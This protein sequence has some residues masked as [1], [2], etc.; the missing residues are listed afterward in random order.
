MVKKVWKNMK[1][2]VMVCPPPPKSKRGG[3][4]FGILAISTTPIFEDFGGHFHVMCAQLRPVGTTLGSVRRS[5]LPTRSSA[6][7][8]LD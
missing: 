5:R 3:Q 1:S 8:S 2:H 4:A 7:A 6:P